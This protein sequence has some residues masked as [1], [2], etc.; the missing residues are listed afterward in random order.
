MGS[1]GPILVHDPENLKLLGAPS[2]SLLEDHEP[3]TH[4]MEPTILVS[5]N[6]TRTSPRT[7]LMRALAQFRGAILRDLLA[8]TPALAPHSAHTP[9]KMH[10]LFRHGQRMHRM[11]YMRLHANENAQA[12]RSMGSFNAAPLLRSAQFDN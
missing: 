5:V 2:L 3:G 1:A 7:Y 12:D 9:Q 6:A 8:R 4:A 11:Q 10:A